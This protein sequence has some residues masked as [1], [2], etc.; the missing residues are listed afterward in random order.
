MT[1]ATAPARVGKRERAALEELIWR[2]V[3]AEP[4]AFLAACRTLDEHAD[5]SQQALRPF[6]VCALCALDD[7]ANVDVV[8]LGEV[9]RQI[10]V[11]RAHGREHLPYVRDVVRWWQAAEIG[12]N[13]K[14]RQML[15]SWIMAILHLHLAMVRPGA[16]IA[17]QSLNLTKAQELLERAALVY[18]AL[19]LELQRFGPLS[20]APKALARKIES[21]L[22]F[23]HVIDGRKVPSRIMAIPNGPHH[24]RMFTFTAIFI[25]EAQ[26]WERDEDFEESYAAA[27]ATVKG[28]GKL[29]AISS[30]NHAGCFHYKL[31]RG[32]I[33][34]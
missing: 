31:C 18:R 7:A 29:T 8:V 4:I 27:L 33:A 25:D 28:G 23:V 24:V 34:A 15:M 22:R 9:P 1:T 13:E 10:C 5:P 17:F 30:V 6:P 21:E 14:S 3:A 32:L 2:R 11:C 26:L 19:P 16:L 12:L 20:D